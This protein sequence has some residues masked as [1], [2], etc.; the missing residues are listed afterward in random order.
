MEERVRAGNRRPVRWSL[1][2]IPRWILM[3]LVACLTLAVSV[4]LGQAQSAVELRALWHRRLSG[5]RVIPYSSSTRLDTSDALAQLDADPANTNQVILIY[6]GLSL[7]A[8]TFG[9]SGGWN[10]EHLW[11]NSYGL[12]EVEPAFSD[13]HNLRACDSNANSARGNKWYDLS[14]PAEGGFRSPAH[15][16]APGTSTDS[17]SW[18]PPVRERGDIARALFYMDVRYEG[19]VPG[20][21]ELQLVQHVERISATNALMGR[22][23]TLLRWNRNDPPDD[24]E[25]RRN[26]AVERWQGNRNPFV[27]NPELAELLF[28]PAIRVG[29]QSGVPVVIRPTGT[30][31]NWLVESAGVPFGPWSTNSL[32]GDRVFWRLRAAD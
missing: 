32:T 20:E 24:R 11:P 7:P 22:L 17:N 5:H 13:L 28:V 1:R 26:S 30:D 23:L 29:F 31:I 21:P 19:D 9:R 3:G 15:A 10:R 2:T 14:N 6:G 12:D 25:R 16:E 8:S 4:E 18:E 27:D